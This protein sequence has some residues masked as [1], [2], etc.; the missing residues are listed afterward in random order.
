MS[1]NGLLS[2]HNS[3]TSPGNYFDHAEQLKKPCTKTAETQTSMYNTT[4]HKSSMYHYS[5]RIKVATTEEDEEAHRFVQEFK[6]RRIALKLTQSDIGE[7]L[8]QRAGAR[9]GQSYI[10]RMESIQLSTAIVLRMKPLLLKLLEEK[11][12]ERRFMKSN[13][14]LDEDEYQMDRK[15]KKRTNFSPEQSILLTKYFAEQPRPSPTEIDDISNKIGVDRNSVKMWF[16]NK[17]QSEKFR[18]Q[19][20]PTI[21]SISSV[22]SINPY[23]IPFSTHMPPSFIMSGLMSNMQNSLNNMTPSVTT[24]SL[25]SLKFDYNTINQKLPNNLDTA[26]LVSQPPFLFNKDLSQFYQNSVEEAQNRQRDND[27]KPKINT[28]DL[29][30]LYQSRVEEAQNRLLD[31][32]SHMK[33]NKD[34]SQLYQNTV[35]STMN[36]LC[37]E[38]LDSLVSSQAP[39]NKIMENVPLSLASQTPFMFS[40]DL[41]QLYQSRSEESQSPN[42]NINELYKRGLEDNRNKFSGV[43]SMSPNGGLHL[44]SVKSLSPPSTLS[45]AFSLSQTISRNLS[46]SVMNQ[47]PSTTSPSYSDTP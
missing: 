42:N 4:S 3:S 47:E 35:A 15:R 39:T 27:V 20:L 29:S 19:P 14:D 40:K 44:S 31:E 10:S 38:K 16:N 22:S 28:K 46:Q 12:V 11:E 33:L 32:S 6:A 43:P 2:A 34:L 13:S 9:Y 37:K 1:L 21:G 45:P 23:A 8:N 30:Q 41:S 18:L 24:A 25:N 26:S 17:R 36:N 5:P 7:E